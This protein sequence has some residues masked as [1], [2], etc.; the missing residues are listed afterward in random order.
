MKSVVESQGAPSQEPPTPIRILKIAACPS[1]SGKSSLTYHVGCT[2][3]AE[4]TFRVFANSGG[5]FFSNEWVPLELVQQAFAK[6]PSAIGITAH[7]L[8]S[9]YLGKSVNTPSF[10]FAA[11]K[12]EGYCSICSR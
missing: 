5:G 4:V 11:L 10:L 9:L 2:P 12:S 8:G 3:N 7:L 6:L 1:L